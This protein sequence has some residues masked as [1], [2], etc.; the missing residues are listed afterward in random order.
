MGRMI[1][2]VR[3]ISASKTREEKEST[4][5]QGNSYT[6]RYIGRG[7]RFLAGEFVKRSY[8]YDYKKNHSDRYSNFDVWFA[9]ES[10]EA[11]RVSSFGNFLLSCRNERVERVLNV[12]IC[13]SGHLL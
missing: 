6:Y 11:L 7:L 8:A 13:A 5:F 1:G 10:C 2:A 12:Q 4:H 3:S 9:F